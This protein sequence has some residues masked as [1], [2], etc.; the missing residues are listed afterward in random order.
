[1]CDRLSTWLC[2]RQRN[3]AAKEMRWCV[4]CR[5]KIA[6]PVPV[7]V[8]VPACTAVPAPPIASCDKACDHGC[9]LLSCTRCSSETRLRPRL[10][11][12]RPDGHVLLTLHR[13]NRTPQNARPRLHLRGQLVRHERTYMNRLETCAT[14][15]SANSLFAVP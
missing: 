10:R 3:H 5:A 12:M 15:C 6:V 11:R 2:G 14:N 13:I 1:M 9:L 4:A 8:P 7:P